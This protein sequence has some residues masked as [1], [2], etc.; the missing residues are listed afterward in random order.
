[1]TA[2][3]R[4]I[5]ALS[6]RKPDRVPRYEIYLDG[7]I[8]AWRKARDAAGVANIY[9]DYGKVDIG[10]VLAMNEGPFPER[11]A[12]SHRGSER[13]R[14]LCQRLGHAWSLHGVLLPARRVGPA[15]R[16]RR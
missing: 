10:S 15:D 2:R 14:P 4:V 13:R 9:D 6:H 3:Q 8:D 11:G 5:E 12:A 1:M 16:H 7:Y